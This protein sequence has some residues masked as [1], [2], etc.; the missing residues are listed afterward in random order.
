MEE[1]KKEIG[2]E[3]EL[4]AEEMENINGAGFIDDIM[5]DI[6]KMKEKG[7]VDFIKDRAE[8]DEIRINNSKKIYKAA[9]EKGIE[10]VDSWIVRKIP[11]SLQ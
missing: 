2:Q 6:E 3:K 9:A 10:K 7:I 1:N 4:S 5:Y 8:M 11:G